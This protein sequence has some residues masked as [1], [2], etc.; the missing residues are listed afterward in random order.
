MSLVWQFNS[1]GIATKCGNYQ[2]QGAK[3]I[4]VFKA[5]RCDKGR[6]KHWTKLCDAESIEDAMALC[7]ADQWRTDNPLDP[8]RKP[9]TEEDMEKVAE[10]IGEFVEQAANAPFG[11]RP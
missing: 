10:A 5:D 7:E 6:F 2:V 9:L 8:N 11:A 1:C 4:E 3:P